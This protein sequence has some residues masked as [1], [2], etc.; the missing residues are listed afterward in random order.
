MPYRTPHSDV[1]AIIDAP[2]TPVALL[3]PG[4]LYAVLV[5]YVSHPPIELLARPYLPL[6][7]IRVD[8][9][10]A[11]R[12]RVRPLTGLSVLRVADGIQRRLNLPDG[13]QP[14]VPTWAPDG[15]RFAFTVDEPD[16]IGVWVADADSATARQV[17]GLRVRDV[18]GGDPL[19]V[20]ATVRWSRDGSSLL[21]LGAPGR[22]A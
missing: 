13:A 16:G 6:A 22:R 20:G 19:T 5:H 14:S 1:V 17:P 11:C 18:L 2:P 4:G 21:A 9:A 8:P 7:G 12:Q 3:A 15:R 10:L